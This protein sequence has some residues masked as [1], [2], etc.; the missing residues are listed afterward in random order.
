MLNILR[1]GQRAAQAEPVGE[2]WR[3]DPDVL[4]LDL[5][6]PT[7]DEELAVEAAL[8]LQL[9]TV[10]EMQALEP[11]SRL[12]QECGG[13]FMTATLLA[14]SHENTPFATPVTFVAGQ[15]LLVTLRYQELRAFSIFAERAP[16]T[17]SQER[18]RGAAGSAMDAIVERLAKTLDDMGRQGGTTASGGDLQPRAGR[19]TSGRC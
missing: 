3:P 10:E 7:R 11:S 16:D 12:Y 6:K 2:G 17:R 5:L 15:G 19:R 1:R 14:R 13:T 18:H 4:W 8:G 9:P